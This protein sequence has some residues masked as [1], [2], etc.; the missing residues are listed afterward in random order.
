[1]DLINFDSWTISPPWLVASFF[2]LGS[3]QSLSP[4][5]TCTESLTFQAD[6]GM[7]LA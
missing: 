5:D 2:A 7:R 4:V 6:L 3:C 1:M